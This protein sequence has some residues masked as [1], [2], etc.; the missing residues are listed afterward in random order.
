MFL[1]L[2]GYWPLGGLTKKYAVGL[3]NSRPYG[4]RTLSP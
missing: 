2:N 1:C 4:A 3:E